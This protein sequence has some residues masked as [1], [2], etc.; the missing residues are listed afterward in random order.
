[1]YV[2]M[3]YKIPPECWNQSIVNKQYIYIG[4]LATGSSVKR[5]GAFVSL[6]VDLQGQRGHECSKHSQ[7]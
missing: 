2:E 3:K 6:I 5:E 1:M 7:K 4:P